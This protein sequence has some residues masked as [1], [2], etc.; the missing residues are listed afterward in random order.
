MPIRRTYPVE[1]L[2]CPNSAGQR[3][4]GWK[5][6]PTVERR[7]REDCEG[8]RILQLFGGRSRFGT[9]LVDGISE[10]MRRRVMSDT[11]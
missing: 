9:R 5:F 2:W 7:I 10:K 4:V 3:G 6:P 8:H 11:R 1:V